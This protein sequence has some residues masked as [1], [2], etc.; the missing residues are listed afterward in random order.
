MKKFLKKHRV[1]LSILGLALVLIVFFAV[2]L[3]PLPAE[4]FK[5]PGLPFTHKK[6]LVIL[7]N[8][9]ELRPTGGFITS[10]IVLDF[11][12]GIPTGFT[13]NDVYFG[14]DQHEYV[15]PPY[16][17]NEL[18]GYEFYKGHTFRDANFDPDFPSSAQKLLDFYR[19]TKPAAD[20]D[21]V[22]AVNYSALEDALEV[23]GDISVSGMLL[24]HENVFES[25]EHYVSN[26]DRHDLDQIKE[27]KSVLKDLAKR[28]LKR[29]VASPGKYRALS[30]LVTHE[31]ETKNII[32]WFNNSISEYDDSF[33]RDWKYDF[34]AFNSANY[35]GMKTDRYIKRNVRY[36]LTIG[37]D[38]L[39]GG[40]A[41]KADVEVEMLHT[42]GDNIPLS[43]GY[44]GY[45]RLYLPR[46]AALDGDFYIEPND[47]YLVAG[48]II[49]LLPGESVKINYSYDLPGSVFDGENYKLHLQKQPGTSDHYAVYVRTPNGTS[50]EST[51]F[52]SRENTA[53][54]E[55]K[56]ERDL[57]LELKVIPDKF[58]PRLV[59]QDFLG[60][61]TIVL[62]FNEN[63]PSSSA[64]DP[65]NYKV[66]DLNV[67]RPEIDQK[68]MIESIEHSG[69][70]V[71]INLT[72][73]IDQEDEHFSVELGNIFDLSGNFIEPNPKKITIV[74]N[75]IK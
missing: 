66:S 72:E 1:G 8:D 68:V 27:R 63:L 11:D 4:I 69:S 38:N 45:T 40:Y 12:H 44:S 9:A 18:L 59:F 30:K 52:E 16:P 42:G 61:D 20:F 25:L 70:G 67:N 36:F 71:F 14:I 39:N 75:F 28:I 15:E 50:I 41:L 43:G 51:D 57:N 65:L 58:P 73:P 23:L 6:Y 64:T 34:L 10:Y 3:A 46:G 74:Q 5:I 55:G 26:I 37:Q 35:G 13:M 2:S 33:P 56:L 21:G 7:Q 47:N 53:S 24:T 31:L 29:A 62:H 17:L 49:K 32:L 22:F 19:M 60:H 54:F 48:K